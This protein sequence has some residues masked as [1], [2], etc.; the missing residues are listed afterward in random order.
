[1]IRGRRLPTAAAN[2]RP[3]AGTLQEC[4][5]IPVERDVSAFASLAPPKPRPNAFGEYTFEQTAAY[6]GI[7]TRTLSERIKNGKPHPHFKVRFGR[8]YFRVDL[9]DR[10]IEEGDAAAA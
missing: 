3:G 10:F 1:M 9:L 2:E 6:L 4:R 7:T 8:R 5:A